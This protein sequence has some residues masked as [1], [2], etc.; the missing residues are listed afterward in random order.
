MFPVL[1]LSKHVRHI[2]KGRQKLEDTR[3]FLYLGGNTVDP[4]PGRSDP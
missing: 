3:R 4:P 1:L 2:K